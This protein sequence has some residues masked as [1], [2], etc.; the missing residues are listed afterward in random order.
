MVHTH[1]PGGASSAHKVA[2]SH[3]EA[4]CGGRQTSAH[5]P[6]PWLTDMGP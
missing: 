1:R 6:A 2:N 5:L 3:G 4:A